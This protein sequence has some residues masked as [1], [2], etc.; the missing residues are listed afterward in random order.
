MSTILL[1]ITIGYKLQLSVIF[2]NFQQII[3]R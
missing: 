1:A 2:R 3:E